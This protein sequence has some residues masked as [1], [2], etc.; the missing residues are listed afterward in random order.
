MASNKSGIV[1]QIIDLIPEHPNEEWFIPSRSMTVTNEKHDW[2]FVFTREPDEMMEDNFK[3]VHISLHNLLDGCQYIESGI[4]MGEKLKSGIT[5]NVAYKIF[6]NSVQRCISDGNNLPKKGTIDQKT[7]LMF[8]QSKNV[9]LAKKPEQNMRRFDRVSPD[10]DVVFPFE[11]IDDYS[12]HDHDHI[13]D[14]WKSMCVYGK[15]K[16]KITD[17]MVRRMFNEKPFKLLQNRKQNF[18]MWRYGK[19]GSA[20]PDEEFVEKM[21]KTLECIGEYDFSVLRYMVKVTEDTLDERKKKYVNMYQKNINQ[22]VFRIFSTDTDLLLNCLYFLEFARD[23]YDLPLDYLPSIIIISPWHSKRIIHVTNMFRALKFVIE[24]GNPSGDPRTTI[25]SFVMTLFSWGNDHLPSPYFIVGKCYLESFLNYRQ[26]FGKPL[27]NVNNDPFNKYPYQ[28]EIN[29]NSFKMLY[30]LAYAHKHIPAKEK[31]K[32]WQFRSNGTVDIEQ[33]E[34][35]IIKTLTTGKKALNNDKRPQGKKNIKARLIMANHMLYCI[36]HALNN[37]KGR[38]KPLSFIELH[39][40][41]H[42][43]LWSD[44]LEKTDKEAHDYAMSLGLISEKACIY[45][46]YHLKPNKKDDEIERLVEYVKI[47]KQR[48]VFGQHVFNRNAIASCSTDVQEMIDTLHEEYEM[49]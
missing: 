30:L 37:I 7:V 18:Y 46:T 49:K 12:I 20:E 14:T 11:H 39:D 29:G 34:E 33:L 2:K 10:V 1:P 47:V 17:Y 19:I 6:V 13:P 40:H 43:N 22:L 23:K 3:K 31:G 45:Y 27:V 44:Y 26:L 21:E 9:S 36:E 41:T 15:Y 16:N 8:D 42:V 4:P 48:F 32:L 28:C 35:H 24:N 5:W 25:R 38:N